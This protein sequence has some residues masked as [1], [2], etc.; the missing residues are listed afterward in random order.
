MCARDLLNN[1]TR[2]KSINISA[3]IQEVFK[4]LEIHKHN[5]KL[6][7]NTESILNALEISVNLYLQNQFRHKKIYTFQGIFTRFL[8]EQL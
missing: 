5:S 1:K 7:W 4:A 3:D 6:I 2:H 8:S